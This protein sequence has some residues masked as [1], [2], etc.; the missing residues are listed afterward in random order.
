MAS[1]WASAF[2]FPQPIT[3]PQREYTASSDL[4]HPLNR[5]ILRHPTYLNEL[6]SS[7]ERLAPLPS[8][9][10]LRT[11]YCTHDTVSAQMALDSFIHLHHLAIVL[12][13]TTC[14]S[15]CTSTRTRTYHT[16]GRSTYAQSVPT[17]Q[18]REMLAHSKHRRRL[19]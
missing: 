13:L 12:G 9:S 3:A 5:N 2:P 8:Y 14:F 6:C 11:V 16:G 7:A 1:F 18:S 4:S 10:I 15:G 17:R 19:V